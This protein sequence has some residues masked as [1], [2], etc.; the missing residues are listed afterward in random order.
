VTSRPAGTGTSA[1][2]PKSTR[3]RAPTSLLVPSRNALDARSFPRRADSLIFRYSLHTESAS[4]NESRKKKAF[5]LER[6]FWS[7]SQDRVQF[8][9]LRQ[10]LIEILAEKKR[11]RGSLEKAAT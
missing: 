8:S 10:H 4:H 3:A 2:S 7:P 6:R 11:V 5:G 1:H 9:L